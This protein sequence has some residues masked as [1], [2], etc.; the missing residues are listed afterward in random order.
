MISREGAHNIMC[1]INFTAFF[2]HAGTSLNVGVHLAL[3]VLLITI[4]QGAVVMLLC[5]KPATD[6]LVA[7]DQK[8]HSRR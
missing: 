7:E 5:E 4:S 1:S 8:V 3:T 6:T 2:F